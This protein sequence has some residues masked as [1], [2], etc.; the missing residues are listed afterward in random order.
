MTFHDA[1]PDLDQIQPGPGGWGKWTWVP[2]CD[3]AQRLEPEPLQSPR[4][5]VQS[6]VVIEA[7][8]E[9]AETP[10]EAIGALVEA[11]LRP[12][13]QRLGWVERPRLMARLDD[14]TEKLLTVV[15]APA[16]YGKTTAVAQWLCKT[17]P[18]RLRIWVAPS[19]VDDDPVRLWTLIGTVM[20]R[21]GLPVA[22]DVAGFVANGAD[23][24]AR[25][26]LPHFADAMAGAG[27]LTLVIDDFD[28]IRSPSCLDQVQTL[29][30]M[31]PDNAHLVVIGRADPA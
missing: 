17:D 23:D 3:D 15:A 12:P 22:R 27:H 18:S 31:L 21:A 5:V 8:S 4:G 7:G 10:G 16:G 6:L 24:P 20:Q 29:I 9:F 30:G 14:C 11:K 19:A 2:N 25:S 1:E 28:R 26:V 13:P